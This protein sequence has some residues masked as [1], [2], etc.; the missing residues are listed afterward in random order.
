MMAHAQLNDPRLPRALLNYVAYGS[1]ILVALLAVTAAAAHPQQGASA[2]RDKPHNTVDVI[3]AAQTIA[4]ALPRHDLP[5][6]LCR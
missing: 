3:K 1:A 5:N 2:V 6:E 4:K